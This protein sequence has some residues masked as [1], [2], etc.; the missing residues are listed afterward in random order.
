MRAKEKPCTHTL[1]TFLDNHK[2]LGLGLKK[3]K[4]LAGPKKE[5]GM[6]TGWEVDR[7][8]II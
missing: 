4:K 8:G 5:V 6:E 3:K 1:P 2:V 7:K